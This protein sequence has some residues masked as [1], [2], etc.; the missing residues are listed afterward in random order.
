MSTFKIQGGIPLKGKVTPV[1]NKNSILP[2]ICAC[3]LTNETVTL[4]N[5]PKSSSV[6]VILNLYKKLGGKVAYLPNNTLK[7]NGSEINSYILDKE[8]SKK[9]RSSFMFLGSLL[10]R[11]KKA[12]ISDGGGCKLG[13]RPIDTLYQGLVE[14]GAKF[15]PNNY[16]ELHTDRL[17]GKE[18]WL[19]EASVTSTEN[20]IIAAVLAK[21]STKIFNAACEPHVQD[22]C[23]FLNHIGADIT[24]VGSN[25]IT[26]N[27][28]E[29]LRGGEWEIIADHLDVGGMMVAAAI[30]GGEITIENAIP[31][32]MRPIL[33]NFEKLNL[34]Y[35]IKGNDIYV[36]ADQKLI[37]KK[38]MKGDIDIIR[39]EP[40]PGF[41]VD[42]LP[43]ALALALKAEGSIR[44]MNYMY[45]AGL[46]FSEDLRKF[47]AGLIMADPHRLITFGPSNFKGATITAADIIQA[48]HAEVLVALA[49][50][51]ESRIINTTPISRRYPDFIQ[52]LKS[53]GAK[54]EKV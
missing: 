14:L 34:K 45:E 38:N 50:N 41:P 40:W 37:C 20:L 44:I 5:V 35:E 1:A 46:L 53:L 12:K 21:G 48:A 36:P 29:E 16:Y 39:A 8:L 9:E 47:R 33:N 22:L 17:V 13:N 31:E 51:G 26:V 15:N 18:I 43:Q 10:S 23:N 3:V 28:V 42:L 19:A 32:H 52:T 6:R 30:T 49:A 25:Q 54:I 11:F 7:L 27:G 4:R 24:G 2:I